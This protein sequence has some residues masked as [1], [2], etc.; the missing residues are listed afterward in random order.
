MTQWT[1]L[2]RNNN[3][4]NPQQ[5]PLLCGI[6]GTMHLGVVGLTAGWLAG[7]Q[8]PSGQNVRVFASFNKGTALLQQLVFSAKACCN[9]V[10][11]SAKKIWK[12]YISTIKY[13]HT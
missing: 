7:R 8:N 11:K 5:L 9:V 13:Y 12:P 10:F 4:I 6:S 3:F 2:N 1:N